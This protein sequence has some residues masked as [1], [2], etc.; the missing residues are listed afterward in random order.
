MKITISGEFRK[1]SEKMHVSRGTMHMR[2]PGP[3]YRPEQHFSDTSQCF[4]PILAT[5]L[6]VP[7]PAIAAKADQT[8]TH[9]I[10]GCELRTP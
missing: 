7:K 1:V 4:R 6:Y 8:L 3:S 5:H 10:S 2:T 9:W